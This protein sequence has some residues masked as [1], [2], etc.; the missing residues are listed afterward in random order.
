MG[1]VL[2]SVLYHELYHHETHNHCFNCA[3]TC[4]FLTVPSCC[5]CSSDTPISP[6]VMTPALSIMLQWLRRGTSAS[7]A[8]AALTS[9]WINNMCHSWADKKIHQ[10]SDAANISTISKRV[11]D[12]IYIVKPSAALTAYSHF[13]AY[14]RFVKWFNNSFDP[15]TRKFSID[16]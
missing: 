4:W 15:R 16:V 3:E 14:C 1:C 11:G 10:S 7:Q 2:F 13:G 8:S 12:S 9:Y 5:W 6:A